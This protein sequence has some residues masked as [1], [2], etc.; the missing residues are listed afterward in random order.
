MGGVCLVALLVAARELANPIAVALLTLF[1]LW[2]ERQLAWAR[3]LITLA[4]AVGVV[5]LVTDLG[6]ALAPFAIALAV[7]YFLDPAV[8]RLEAK[9][10]NRSLAIFLM[11]APV[12]TAIAWMAVILVPRLITEGAEFLR[13]LPELVD[14]AMRRLEHLPERLGWTGNLR[15]VARDN[16][17]TLIDP[18]EG[19]VRQLTTGAIGVGRGLGAGLR[20]ATAA[21]VT[22]L[23]TFYALRDIDRF[24][25][26]LGAHVPAGGAAQELLAD[27]DHMLGRYLRGQLIVSTIV[28]TL[29]SAGLYALDVPYALLLGILTGLLNIV[30][31]VGFWIA[32]VPVLLVALTMADPTVQLIK[33]LVFYLVVQA[34]EGNVIS[35]RVVGDE[36]GLN[37]VVM[38]LSI[39]VFSHVFGPTGVIIA[40]PAAGIL[41]LLYRR[42]RG[43]AADPAAPQPAVPEEPA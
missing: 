27:I 2:P 13:A 43:S 21:V 3:R 17:P 20:L 16:L 5:W 23:A 38:I 33:V 28:A 29:T 22:P 36:L 6:S 15:E 18:L 9:G 34:L 25:A 37:P 8:D 11:I 10:L 7:A 31:I 39:V 26:T 32:L 14:Q 12:F 1:L 30:P 42:W 35:P 19:L 4:I 40:V 41:A 24:K